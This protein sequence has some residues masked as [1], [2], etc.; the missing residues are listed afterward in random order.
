MDFSSLSEQS[1][2][3]S[4]LYPRAGKFIDDSHRSP[5]RQIAETLVEER[6]IL[7]SLPRNSHPEKQDLTIN[8]ISRVS[9]ND[10]AELVQPGYG[11][12]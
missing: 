1:L 2:R 8:R 11:I 3:T 7:R 4:R 5:G 12:A 10:S 9:R 6:S